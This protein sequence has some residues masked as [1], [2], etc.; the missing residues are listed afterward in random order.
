M[1]PIISIV[2]PAYNQAEF[3]PDAL[4]SALNQTV[5]CEVTCIVD[6]ATDGSLE[7]AKGYEKKG[8]KVISQTNRGLAS[9]RNTGIMNAIGD[10]VIPLDSDDILLD[11]CAE[12]ITKAIW[13]TNADIISPSFKE[14]GLSQAEVILMPNPT[15]ED[16]K[17]ANRV[18]Y[19]SAIRRS[20]LLAV[21]GY[22]PKMQLGFEDFDLWFDL[23]KRNY[24]IVTIPE[25]LWL[26]RVK[27]KSM[28]VNAKKHEFELLTQI[29]LNHPEL[30]WPLLQKPENVI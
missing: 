30:K 8:V 27:A 9:A 25:I 29:R 6:G 24:K 28:Y 1:K 26:Y 14:F 16:F 12:R 22:N 7:I 19:C 4:D 13:E 20:V 2:V 23:L 17:T 21:G 3:L 15:L 5:E 18:G 10:F 11:N